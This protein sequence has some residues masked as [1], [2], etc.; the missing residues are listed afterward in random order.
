MVTSTSSPPDSELSCAWDSVQ[1]V[2]LEG[3]H[4]H[5]HEGGLTIRNMLRTIWQLTVT[6]Q[7]HHCSGAFPPDD[8]LL[9]VST[10]LKCTCTLVGEI[11][12]PNTSLCKLA[13]EIIP[14]NGDG[15]TL[16]M[17]EVEYNSCEDHHYVFYSHR[18]FLKSYMKYRTHPWPGA[19][20]HCLSLIYEVHTHSTTA[21]LRLGVAFIIL[22]W[23]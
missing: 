14:P 1:H 9:T 5:V 19:G 8:S 17:V 23:P 12:L 21:R 20:T 6:F 2:T 4:S 3:S 16:Q 10:L 15:G 22:P 11:H 18:A 7:M 13:G